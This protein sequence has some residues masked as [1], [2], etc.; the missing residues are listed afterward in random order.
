MGSRRKDCYGKAEFN[1]VK[2]AAKSARALRTL[3]HTVSV[4]RMAAPLAPWLGLPPRAK[5]ALMPAARRTAW[6][7]E[8]NS[9]PATAWQQPLITAWQRSGH[10]SGVR[11]A[12]PSSSW[13]QRHTKPVVGRNV[14]TYP[15]AKHMPVEGHNGNWQGQRGESV[16]ASTHP[17]VMK[18]THGEGVAFAAGYPNFEPWALATVRCEA[19]ILQGTSGDMRKA[20]GLW[21]CNMGCEVGL[22]RQLRKQRGMVWHHVEDGR[23][24]HL[25]PNLL[26][27]N[28]P[29]AGG[30]VLLRHARR[31]TRS[32]CF[33]P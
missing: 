2:E 16:W 3:E 21:A 15:D 25:L 14:K 1:A 31:A 11:N 33:Q 7:C 19:G 23:T 27:A 26:H 5:V 32:S 13:L 10:A 17:Q 22:A 12:K 24:M 28:I 30:A 18:I 29:H 6:V 8:S 4:W 20:D 9:P